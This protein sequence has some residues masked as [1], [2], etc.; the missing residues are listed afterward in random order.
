MRGLQSIAHARVARPLAAVLAGLLLGGCAASS[1]YTPGQGGKYQYAYA[2]VAPSTSADL[3]HR[4]ERI[5]IQFRPDDAAMKFQLQNLSE[6]ELTVVWDRASIGVEGRFSPVRHASSLYGDSAVS[7]SFL[8]PPMGYMRDLVMPAENIRFDGERWV[9]ADLLPTTDRGEDAL[10]T[11]IRRSVGK[12]VSVIL[13]LRF[14]QEEVTYEFA[15]R[16]SAVRS[17]AWR[18]HRP[19]PRE[20]SPPVVKKSSSQIDQVTLA[21]IAVGVLGFVAYTLSLSKNPPTE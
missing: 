5:I 14:G 21:V 17:I 3:T 10:R 12:Q 8:L 4:D 9:E 19:V 16:V 20:P 6:Q 18:D 2:M 15:F 11:E 13:P 1:G 7:G